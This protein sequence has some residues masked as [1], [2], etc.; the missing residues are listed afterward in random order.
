MQKN[1]FAKYYRDNLTPSQS[2]EHIDVY[3]NIFFFLYENY[4]TTRLYKGDKIV[5]IIFGE[6]IFCTPF[7][8][9]I[10]GNIRNFLQS[11]TKKGS[12]GERGKEIIRERKDDEANLLTVKLFA[13]S[14][15]IQYCTVVSIFLLL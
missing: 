8:F 3:K 5:S 11:F 4:R 13:G 10:S 12:M 2:S 9:T 7:I 6:R 15:Q 14:E 1:A